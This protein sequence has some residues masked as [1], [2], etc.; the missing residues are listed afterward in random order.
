MGATSGLKLTYFSPMFPSG[1]PENIRNRFPAFGLNTERYGVSLRILSYCGKLG[2]D[3]F[4]LS[5]GN[6]EK[7]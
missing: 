3:V 2:S 1:P 5:K 4:G 6:V 7:K